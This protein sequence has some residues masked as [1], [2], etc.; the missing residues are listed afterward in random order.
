MAPSSVGDFA[1]LFIG[2]EEVN[3][4]ADTASALHMGTDQVTFVKMDLQCR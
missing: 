2:L 1:T 3:L 4:K